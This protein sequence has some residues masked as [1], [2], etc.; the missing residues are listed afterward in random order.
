MVLAPV[1]ERGGGGDKLLLPSS[2]ASCEHNRLS[3]LLHSRFAPATPLRRDLVWS[4][5]LSPLPPLKEMAV[6]NHLE[7]ARHAGAGDSTGATL[8]RS[9]VRAPRLVA[10]HRPAP[11]LSS[12]TRSCSASYRRPPRPSRPSTSRRHSRRC[13]QSGSNE[14]SGMGIGGEE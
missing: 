13:A 1:G 8:P 6:D 9:S 5:Y 4:R 14:E 10:A 2:S 7:A 3:I 12:K 11:Q